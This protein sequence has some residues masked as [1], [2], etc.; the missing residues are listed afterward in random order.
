MGR[1]FFLITLLGLSMASG[2]TW[3]QTQELPELK[4]AQIALGDSL[5]QLAV[6]KLQRLLTR[7]DLDQVA[8]LHIRALLG[9]ALVRSDQASEAL[10]V[11]TGSGP[12]SLTWRAHALTQLGKLEKAATLLKRIKTDEAAYQRAL[13]LSSLGER[14]QALK[15]LSPIKK[16]SAR[17]RTLAVSILLDL[18]RIDEAEPLLVKILE[19]SSGENPE[20]R[21]LAA[22]L[23]LLRK[24]R[25]AAIGSFQTLVQAN[26]ERLQLPAVFVQAAHL[27]LADS[28]ALEGNEKEAVTALFSTLRKFPSST[29]LS[30]IFSRLEKW[31][32]A[33]DPAVLEE[34][35]GESKSAI[36]APAFSSDAIVSATLSP[37]EAPGTAHFLYLAALL[38]L[39]ADR[40]RKARALLSQLRMIS[41]AGLDELF[42]RSL[43]QTGLSHLK[44]KQFEL[45]YSA[46]SLLN[47]EGAPRRTLAVA[48]G[49]QG[50]ASY[51]LQEPK[52]ALE[53]FK[54]AEKIAGDFDE[55]VLTEAAAFNAAVASLL[56]GRS[57]SIKGLPPVTVDR[58]R[59]ERGLIL[60]DRREPETLPLLEAYLKDH[61]TSPRRQEVSLA[62]AENYDPDN[63]A[64]AA[65]AKQ[66]LETLKFDEKTESD[67]AARQ[68]L[69]LL[70]LG[71]SFDFA[72]QFIAKNLD[73]P[74]A[75][76][77]LFRQGQALMREESGEAILS[78]ERLLD[79][80][81]D[82]PLAETA[83]FLSARASFSVNTESD[84]ARALERYQQIIDGGGPLATSAAIDL[85]R[86]QIDR[87]E[88]EAA[89]SGIKKLLKKKGLRPQDRRSLFVLGAEAASQNARYDEALRF[90]DK[91]LSQKDLPVAWFNR[92]SF[93]RGRV[94]E[95]LGRQNDA[96]KTYYQVVLN[97]LMPAELTAI[98]WQWHDKCALL[99]ALPLLER[100]N[101]WK[102]ALALALRVAQSGGPS[103]KLAEERAR[104]I[105]FEQMIFEEKE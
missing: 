4:A 61:P 31:R 65:R 11:L 10:R 9:E 87:S 63:P 19:K 42:E 5:P 103:A 55:K 93:L 83:R 64:H 96:L 101:E 76:E 15:I 18:G 53:S 39:D 91:L 99:G 80:F 62:L 24:N 34:F 51:A 59:L 23:Q 68:V 95:N 27:G 32:S 52:R 72:K 26:D 43:I 70:S 54:E 85:A 67:L 88:Q 17:E 44:S 14:E 41:P 29:R 75:P 78:F 8:E 22:R 84:I 45:A 35:I 89:L 16:G 71:E 79:N 90:Y 30:D 98:E 82:H 6:P 86:L 21:Y 74:R 20:L 37:A 1:S 47:E 105:R 69:A 60:A 36:A 58:L 28:L 97:N 100:N 57:P 73:H 49:L 46:F 102:A 104:K 12:K 50:A 56:A 66:L 33:I 81:P 7:K 25:L 94:L 77:L 48:K 40:P 2:L 92:A 38:H 13:I 3:T